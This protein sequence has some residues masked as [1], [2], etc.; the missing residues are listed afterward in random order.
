MDSL[1]LTGQYLAIVLLMALESSFFPFPSEIVIPPAG[2]FAARGDL[3][4][5]L[6]V[7]AGTF[8]SLLGALF[9]YWLCFRWGERIILRLGR[10]FGI[11]PE[12]IEWLK[13]YFAEHG[14]ITTF[15][16]RVIPGIRQYI[17]LPAGIA[18]M[19]ILRFSLYTCLGA[20]IWVTILAYVGFYVGKNEAL[21]RAVLRRYYPFLF[22]A[23]AC[24][25]AAYV[26]LYKRRKRVVDCQDNEK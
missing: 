14:E 26:F 1:L 11:T 17:S 20:G 12:R 7:F 6:V 25:V 5:G 23:I 3:N 10:R 21:V 9:N 15:V 13:K 18:R 2:Y 8:G 4:I 22:L 16:G 24:V 19:S